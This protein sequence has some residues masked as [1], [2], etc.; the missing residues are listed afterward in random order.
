MLSF[1]LLVAGLAGCAR[2][3]GGPEPSPAALRQSPGVAAVLAHSAALEDGDLVF[4][5]GQ[6]ALS[7][8]VLSRRDGSRFSHVGVVVRGADGPGVVHALPD[9]A[10][11][12][13]GVRREPLAAF[14]A[15]AVAGDAA[16]YRVPGLDPAARR[17]LRARLLGRLGQPFDYGF[18]LSTPDRAYCSELAVDALR[19]AGRKVSVPTVP[20]ALANEPVVLPDALAR[21][22]GLVALAG[23]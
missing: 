11:G 1:G 14:L 18:A 2:P 8:L 12:D 17:A 22:P 20:V 4:R 5:R 19:A 7:R 16:A 23:E 9:A 15:P 21:L 3:A 13:G 10:G 6:D